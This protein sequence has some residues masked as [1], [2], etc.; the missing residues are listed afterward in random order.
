V[1]STDLG[2]R[3]RRRNKMAI[4]QINKSKVDVSGWGN[5]KG[6]RNSGKLMSERPTS[7]KVSLARAAK[8]PFLGRPVKQHRSTQDR[9]S[10]SGRPLTQQLLRKGDISLNIIYDEDHCGAFLLIRSDV[11]HARNAKTSCA[12]FEVVKLRDTY[13]AGYVLFRIHSQPN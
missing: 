3:G 8:H 12:V 2:L 4:K 9:S 1:R 7:L 13:Q 11:S 6:V 5:S 10:A